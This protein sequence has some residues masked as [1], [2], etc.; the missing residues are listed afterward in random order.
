V[1]L[2]DGWGRALTR[3]L[4][5]ILRVYEGSDGNATLALYDDLKKFGGVGMIAVELFRAQ[6]SS[7]RAKVYRGGG[8]RG[9]AYD[10]KQW[11]MG[12]L[13][14]A[15]TDHGDIPWGW[16]QDSKQEF[17]NWVLYVNLPAGQVSFHTGERGIGPDYPCNWDGVKNMSAMRICCFIADLFANADA[18]I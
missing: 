16:K 1:G 18:T 7:S 2:D 4:S 15:L 14:Q 12:N 9:K 17:H 6:K 5:E 13:A 8:Y 3:D 10:K 11:A